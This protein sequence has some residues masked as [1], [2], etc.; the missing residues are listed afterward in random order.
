MGLPSGSNAVSYS[1][2]RQRL[3]LPA[4]ANKITLTFW[5]RPG[6]GDASD[7]RQILLLNS[8]G[9]FYRTLSQNTGA[10][11]NQWAQRTLDLTPYK[12]QTVFLYF[13]TYN[14]GAGSLAWNYLDDVSVQSCAPGAVSPT[15]TNTA[16]ATSVP[17]TNTPTATSTATSVPP[18]NTSTPTATAVP[19][20]PT[21]SPTSTPTPVPPTPTFTATATPPPPTATSTSTSSPTATA[22]ATVTPSPT[23]AATL[24][25]TATMPANCAEL[26]GNG[27][28]E[29]TGVWSLGD[30]PRPPGYVT[31][32]VY[33]GAR[34]LRLGILPGSANVASYSS[35]RQAL[36]LPSN[37]QTLTLT[38]QLRPG[39]GDAGDYRDT[40]LFDGAGRV[41]TL[42]RAYGAGNN[43]W[44][45]RTFDLM[46]YRGQTVTLYFNV[47]NNGTGTL[48]AS[49]LDEVSVR[50]CLP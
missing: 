28:F 43:Q 17:P 47:Y 8:A 2:A 23:N 42:E 16:T 6:G 20:T 33:A 22:T 4:S 9:A 15:P 30:T 36:V 18:T 24:T 38:Y 31:S 37:A 32:P 1:S 26:V 40:I 3:V 29:T 45:L 39:A 21:Q 14:N 50:A 5:E 19:P 44:S 13:N 41:R 48:A 11:N 7:Y 25:P 34:A 35:A 12:G 49:H 27:G 46:P 10:G